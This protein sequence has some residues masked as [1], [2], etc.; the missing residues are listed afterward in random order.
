MEAWHLWVIAGVVLVAAEVFTPG[1]VVACIGLGA[2]V[3]AVPAALGASLAW[4]LAAF[5][6]AALVILW[7][8]RP[9]LARWFHTPDRPVRT[10]VSALIGRPGRVVQPISAAAPGRVVVDG[11]DWRALPTGAR[12]FAQGDDVRVTRIDGNTLFVEPWPKAAA[13]KEV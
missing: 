8:A 1:F 2:F 10:N 11:E 7:F 13:V 6:A 9:V 3:A 4:Q 5:C 12:P